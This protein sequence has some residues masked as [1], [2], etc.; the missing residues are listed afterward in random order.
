MKMKKK[1]L[2]TYKIA[3]I[4]H[5]APITVGRWIDEGK[6]P[7]FTTGGGHRRVWDQDLLKFLNLHNYPVPKSL[8]VDRPLRI[9]IVEDE[10]VTRRLI[11]RTMERT[12][13]NAEVH[14]ATDGYEAGEKIS[15]LLP[16]LIILDIW[17]PGIDGMKI[18]KR[19]RENTTT[20]NLKILVVTGS[21]IEEVRKKALSVGAD[22]FLP[23]PFEVDSLV[24][25]S[26]KLL[27]RHTGR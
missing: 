27:S 11:R 9:L 16:D 3:K 1:A 4:C 10:A 12:L 24:K 25:K 22:D 23:K 14:E 6:L 21:H 19:I 18:L 13:S 2:G 20:K 7:Y 5:V 17:L 26:L 8:V 15:T